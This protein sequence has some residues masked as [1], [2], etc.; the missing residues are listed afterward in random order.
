MT[1]GEA[2]ARVI[3]NSRTGTVIIGQHVTVNAAAVAHGN[4]SVTV[5]NVTEVSQPAPLSEGE[6]VVVPN[7]Q[8][9][10]QE[11]DARA[12]VFKPG[13]SL[14]ELV[15]AINRVGATPS[16]LVAILEALRAAGALQAELVVI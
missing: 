9:T 8:I 16:D 6:T 3:V 7:S 2:P 1:P 14:E 4:L 5:S 10:F 12:F 11:E 13:V 15:R